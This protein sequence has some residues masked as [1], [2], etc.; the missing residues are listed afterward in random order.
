MERFKGEIGEIASI[1]LHFL[2]T[3]I[4]AYNIAYKTTIKK[5]R[6]F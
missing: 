6:T 2:F 1:F 4:I 5:I 3:K